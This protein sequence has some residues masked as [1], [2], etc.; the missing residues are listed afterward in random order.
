M[1]EKRILKKI[2]E[3]K[4]YATVSGVA[5]GYIKTENLA[6]R[7]KIDPS[8]FDFANFS[9]SRD[10]FDKFSFSPLEWKRS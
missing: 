8:R 10:I 7:A 1:D 5:P 3:A 6:S 2:H 9:F 4:S